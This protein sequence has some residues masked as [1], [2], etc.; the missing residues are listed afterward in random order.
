[1]TGAFS[2]LWREGGHY[3][4]VSTK[5]LY[6]GRGGQRVISASAEID[7]LVMFL[8]RIVFL[9][10]CVVWV[11]LFILSEEESDPIRAEAVFHSSPGL[12]TESRFR[13]AEIMERAPFAHSK[14]KLHFFLVCKR[15]TQVWRWQETGSK[16]K[17][18]QYSVLIGHR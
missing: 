17:S 13:E 14:G 6:V 16:H 3:E 18:G 8:L 7:L 12:S 10:C 4:G 2:S 15:E 1:M 11:L 5:K 9:L